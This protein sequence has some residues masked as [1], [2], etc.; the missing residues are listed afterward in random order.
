VERESFVKA[1]WFW[2]RVLPLLGGAAITMPWRRVYVL[3]VHWNDERLRRHEAVHLEQIE[4]DG[5]IKF[6]IQYIWWCLRYGY[7]LNP[8][9]VEAFKRD[10]GRWQ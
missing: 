6:S 8:Y 5:A 3:E 7:R 4:R 2:A 9:E 1:G 10:G